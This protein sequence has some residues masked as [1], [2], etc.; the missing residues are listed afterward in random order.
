MTFKSS[1]FN[2]SMDFKMKNWQDHIT[3]DSDVLSGKPVIK[4]TRL[5]VEFILERLASGW[6]TQDLLDS[7]PRLTEDDLTAVYAYSYDCLRDGL[8]YTKSSGPK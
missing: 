1:I 4:G 7:Y 5:A 3:T 8:L 2:D 6:T